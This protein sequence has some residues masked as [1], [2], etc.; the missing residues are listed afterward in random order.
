[1]LALFALPACRPDAA[2]QP[3]IDANK[4]N[5]LNNNNNNNHSNN[6][7]NSNNSSDDTNNNN[8]NT[9]NNNPPPPPPPECE[10][11]TQKAC[12][13]GPGGTLNVGICQAG[14]Q[15]CEQGQWGEC[16]GQILPGLEGCSQNERDDN[17]DGRIDEDDDV[18]GDGWTPCQGDCCEHTQSGCAAEPALVNPGAYEVADNGLDDNCDNLIDNTDSRLCSSRSITTTTT[19]RQLAEAMDLCTFVDEEHIRKPWGVLSSTLSNVSGTVAPHPLQSGVLTQFGPLAP[20]PITP[21]AGATMALLSTGEAR[22]Q[23]NDD[24]SGLNRVFFR[25]SQAPATYLNAHAGTLQTR[26]GCPEGDVQVWDSIRYRLRIR[27]PTNAKGFSYRFRFVS[28]EYPKY[29]C[30]EYNDFFLALLNSQHAEIP[31]DTNISFDAANNPISINNAFFTTCEA[32]TCSKT[33]AG[34]GAPVD[35]YRWSDS[36]NDGCI[37]VLSCDANNLCANALGACPDGAAEVQTYAATT[38]GAGATSWLTTSAP[39][40]PGEIFTLD[41]HLWDTGDGDLD[42]LVI[43]DDFKWLLEAT[44]LGTRPSLV[45]HVQR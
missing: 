9:D 31:A 10:E 38:T 15:F 16:R 42:S 6:S 37:D 22:G 45:H 40:V 44:T 5:P 4:H 8:N 12:Y 43:L 2:E 25:R 35:I 30:S 18:D 32:M 1:M 17:C 28:R 13:T 11:N 29:L 14:S 20:S 21:T 24:Y 33:F 39:I 3:E 19:G 27:A 7:Q 34:S 41:F 23:G 36:N 26:A